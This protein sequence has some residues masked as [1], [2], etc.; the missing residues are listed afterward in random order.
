MIFIQK[1]INKKTV[2]LVVFGS[3][4]F[5]GLISSVSAWVPTPPPPTPPPAT[6]YHATSGTLLEGTPLGGTWKNA[7]NYDSIGWTGIGEPSMDGFSP[8]VIFRL[9]FNNI[10]ADLVAIAFASGNLFRI[11]TLTVSY[12][13]GTTFEKDFVSVGYSEYMLNPNKCVRWV[14]LS[15]KAPIIKI[16]GETNVNGRALCDFDYCSLRSS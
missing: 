5:L 7:H 1:I 15:Y 12:T 4:L 6:W 3:L 16:I 14:Q 9:Y 10:H 2:L 8:Y 11:T 13:D